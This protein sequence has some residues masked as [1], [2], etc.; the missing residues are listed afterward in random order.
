MTWYGI[1]QDELN[2]MMVKKSIDEDII[3]LTAK[4]IVHSS[5]KDYSEDELTY[6]K[7]F[8]ESIDERIDKWGKRKF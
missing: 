6:I 1:T 7:N 2:K 3:D 4:W 8:I 5:K